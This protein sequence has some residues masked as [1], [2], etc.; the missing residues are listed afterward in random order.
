V[1]AL[2]HSLS[3]DSEFVGGF[4]PVFQPVLSYMTHVDCVSSVKYF[5]LYSLNFEVI[6][7]VQQNALIC[8]HYLNI[9]NPYRLLRK[10]NFSHKIFINHGNKKNSQT[11]S[12]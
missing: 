9:C 6:R 10:F 7:A 12:Y 5:T 2:K 11:I 8:L 3:A 4:C 1:K